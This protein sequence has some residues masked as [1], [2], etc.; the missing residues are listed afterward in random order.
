ARMRGADGLDA[1][2]ELRIERLLT[3]RLRRLNADGERPNVMDL[4][5]EFAEHSRRLH[6]TSAGR[7]IAVQVVRG[8]CRAG[9]EHGAAALRWQDDFRAHLIAC[10]LNLPLPHLLRLPCHDNLHRLTTTDVFRRARAALRRR[11]SPRAAREPP[12]LET[13]RVIRAGW[14]S[15]L[16]ASGVSLGAQTRTARRT[17][18]STAPAAHRR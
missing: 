2:C 15:R 17:R 14:T 8:E 3:Q 11:C 16:P 4:E 12:A 6:A 1:L 7:P 18:P 13:Q 10:P 5:T 9:L